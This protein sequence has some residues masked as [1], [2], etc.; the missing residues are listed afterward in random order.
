MAGINDTTSFYNGDGS[1]SL[2]WE[3]TICQSLAEQGSPYQAALRR[4]QPYGGLLAGFLVQELGLRTN[5]S[6]V[7]VGGGTGSLM[8]AL[9]AAVPLTDLTMV[10]ISPLFIA[11]QREALAGRG[12]VRFVT[13]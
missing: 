3:L 5:W 1:P 7:E 8:A 11:R 12:S 6:V 9:L 10:D 4:P 2:F 13:A